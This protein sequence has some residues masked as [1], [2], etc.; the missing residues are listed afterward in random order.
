[1]K[2]FTALL[3][4]LSL[5]LLTACTSSVQTPDGLAPGDSE[6]LVLYTSHKKEVWWPI[7]KEFE[8]RTGI[9]VEVVEGGT[10]ELLERIRSKKDAP[11][12]DVM[13]GGG[14]ESL[15]SYSGCF[16]PYSCQDA[17]QIA[18]QYRSP[19]D[20]WTPFSSLPVVLICNPKLLS[21][22][23]LQSWADLLSPELR[24][25]IAFA[26]PSVSGSSYTGLVTMLYALSE[27]EQDAVLQR[28]AENLDGEAPF[29]LR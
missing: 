21:S 27:E 14:V 13:F 8:S 6:R 9:W 22:E 2:R 12:A 18:A 19:D 11:E 1:M 7:V 23:S 29:R 28:F 24:G 26:D 4:L 16:A 20:V 5:L 17:A 3:L 25:K 10:N 15:Q